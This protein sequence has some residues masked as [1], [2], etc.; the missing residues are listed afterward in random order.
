MA[1][2][3]LARLELPRVPK[4]DGRQAGRF[5]G[6]GGQVQSAIVRHYLGLGRRYRPA[7]LRA[8]GGLRPRGRW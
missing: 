7:G 4:R 3:E 6:E 1:Q 2:H 5:H 8:E